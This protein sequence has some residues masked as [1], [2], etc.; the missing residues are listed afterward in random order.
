MYLL[1]A[2]LQICAAA[3]RLAKIRICDLFR[4]AE[5]VDTVA[6]AFGHSPFHFSLSSSR[7]WVLPTGD[8][9]LAPSRLHIANAASES[10]EFASN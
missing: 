5:P 2:F 9:G 7:R 3:A 10:T 8:A 4:S 6:D 1:L